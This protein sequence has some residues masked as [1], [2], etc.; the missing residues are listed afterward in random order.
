MEQYVGLDVSQQTTAICVVDENGARVWQGECRSAPET[1][2]AIVRCRAPAAVKVALESGPLAVWHWHQLRGLGLPVVC[3]HARHARAAV[4][5]QVNKTDANDAYGLAQLARSGWYRPVEVKS[6]ESY[7]LRALLS[8]RNQLVTIRTR[9]YN[10][11]RGLLKTFGVVLLPGKGGSFKRL[12]EQHVPDDEHVVLAVDGLMRI[13]QEVTAELD[14]LNRRIQEVAK[15]QEI[16][17]R[18]MEIPGVGPIT[19]LAYVTAIDD[20]RRFK[21]SKDVG[22]Y[23]GLTPRRYQSGEVDRVGHVS[24]CGDRLA[25]S[26]LFE[27]AGSLLYRSKLPTSLRPWGLALSRRAGLDKARVALARKLAVLMHR[28]WTDGTSFAAQPACAA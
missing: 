4:D 16:C 25:R 11:V 21:H 10:Q 6:I 19:A 18:L 24:K 9:L 23:L 5:A 1:M 17:R 12:V 14:Q 20:P 3:I 28:M 27:A 26:L 15:K 22:P 2:A 7:R 13:W 8:T